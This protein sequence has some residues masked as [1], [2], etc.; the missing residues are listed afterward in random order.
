MENIIYGVTA[1]IY[2]VFIIRFILNLIG[3]DF[4]MDF[5]ADADLSISDIV[6]FK[7][8]THFL[9]G[10]F[11]WLSTK[12]LITHNIQWYDYLISFVIGLFFATILYYI[13]SLMRKLEHKPTVL[14]GDNLIGSVGTVYL[15]NGD[16][17]YLVTVNNN[18]GT[19]EVSA[20]PED[21]VKFKVG[22]RVSLLKYKNGYYSII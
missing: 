13:Y 3:S 9:M 8:G 22:D 2:A 16:G 15:D 21:E 12:L 17:T 4:D 10:F 20:I 14:N 11:G 5:D 7:G 6:S 18:V 19:T 1:I